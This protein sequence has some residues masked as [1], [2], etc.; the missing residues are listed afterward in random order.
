MNTNRTGLDRLTLIWR[1]GAPEAIGADGIAPVALPLDPPR[2]SRFWSTTEML[3]RAQG[4]SEE[5]RLSTGGDHPRLRIKLEQALAQILHVLLGSGDS[6]V[7]ACQEVADCG[8]L[9]PA[10]FQHLQA[11]RQRADQIQPLVDERVA[12]VG[13]REASGQGSACSR[14]IEVHKLSTFVR[15]KVAPRPQT[16]LHLGHRQQAA[17]CT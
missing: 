10:L 8:T 6:V 11:G 4:S 16:L 2:Q 17:S 7:E 1:H 9:G 12:R 14:I 13:H 5:G 3:R 15:A